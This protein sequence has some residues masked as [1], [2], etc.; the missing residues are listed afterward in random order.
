MV[1]PKQI[2]D[3]VERFKKNE[4]IYKDPKQY[5]EENTKIEFI[6]PFFESLGWDV[7]NKE[8]LSPRYKDVEFE[9]SIKV[10]NE[11]KAPDYAF[12]IGGQPKFFV[13][14]KK[15][16]VKIETD[17][18][19][20]FQIRR[21][22]WSASMDLC[23][24]TDFET[25]AVY[26]TTTRPDKNQSAAI[27][28][29]KLYH[30][31]EYVE[32][33]D[34][35]EEI[36]SKNAV[37]KGDFDNYVENHKGIKKGTSKVDNEFL[38]EIEHW[39]L[40]L[41]RNIALRNSE[42]NIE[43]LNYAVQLIIDRIIFLRIAE[44]RGIE[45][46]GRLQKLLK[47]ENI[48]QEF[49]KL[50]K[51]A[52]EKYNSGLFHFTKE[53][54]DDLVDN[55]TLELKI[56]NK[57]FKE[58][59]KHLYYPESPY[60]F[61]VL[62]LEI[63]GQ[64]YEQFLGKTIRLTPN[65]QAKVEEKGEEKKQGGVYY[66]PQSIVKDMVKDSIGEKIKDKTPSQIRKLRIV[67]PA[68]GSG[69]FL[70]GAYEYLLDYH[71]D[72]Y[73]KLKKVPKDVIYQTKDGELKLTIKEKKEILKNNIYGVDL[74]PLAVEVTKLSLLLKVLEDQNKDTLEQQQKIFQERVLPNLSDNIKCGNSV[75][76]PEGLTPDE[77]QE[78]NAFDWKKEYPTIFNEEE[79]NGFDIVI[80]NP[81]YVRQER[82]TNI[83]SILEKQY[84]VCHGGADLYVYF[85]EKG[86]KLLKE[87][88]GG[89]NIHNF[90]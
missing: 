48:Y 54:D 32:K 47:K 16:S 14:A 49:V 33:W 59:F 18:N 42:L 56:D 69:S 85:Y 5:D 55:Y 84:E 63:L 28:R 13:E 36:F 6:N 80:G 3:L 43:K 58:I 53:T 38:K 64:V 26:E 37:L 27:G 86:L 21:Y 9:N 88:G 52:D 22:G 19:P 71:L 10:K 39:R 90:K 57:I 65:H 15:P 61:S 29:I 62:P 17:K 41:A 77:I 24:L 89:I 7:Y 25:L 45:R 50:C 87:G 78:F 73:T 70:I 46:Y 31:S 23:I 1:A 44:D 35:I 83:K 8:G 68:C 34:E 82:I 67:D 30:Y 81:P 12:R 66:T 60:E 51:K 74:D 40:L 2:G 20:A 4:H 75:I 76:S 11:T 79:N 72:Y